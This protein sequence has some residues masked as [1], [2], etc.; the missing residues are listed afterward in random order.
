YHA[1]G[2][3]LPVRPPV[4]PMLAKAARELP[5]GEGWWYEPK[6]DG[7]RALVFR[8]GGEIEIWSRNE[9]PLTRYFPELP[10]PLAACM[11]EAAVLDGEVVVAGSSG[12]DFDALQARVHPAASR[13]SRLAAETPA[14]FVA[15]DLLC[16]GRDDLRAEPFSRRR[17]LL[18]SALAGA[19]R[20]QVVTTPGTASRSVGLEWFTR[21]E[22]AGLDG[23][24]AKRLDGTY[25]EG[26][27]AMVKVKHER[28]A[29]V[30]VAGFRPYRAGAGVGSLLLG[31]YDAQGV[32]HHVGVAGAF[33]AARR[34]ELVA[35][36]APFR[37]DDRSS[38]PWS[39]LEPGGEGQRRPGGVSRWSAGKDLSWE[40]LRPALVAEV[41][42]DH[43]QGDRFRHAAT[44]RRWRHDRD[45]SGCTYDQLE[46]A[47][48]E[49]L[50]R[51]LGPA[52]GP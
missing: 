27:R 13:V 11:P 12:L 35:E 32:L 20:P 8:D 47:V 50:A 30:V 44:F 45:A 40:A 29:E 18:E 42:Y 52:G 26:R 14:A 41:A 34:K 51:L 2:M 23:V 16:L 33:S 22:G 31:L 43:L 28:T 46:S 3:D 17:S 39:G 9:R 7:F 24:V 48:P 1:A 19:R 21:F 4:A 36:L 15:F 38:H 49:E 10:E 37:V 25:Q 5:E 6:W